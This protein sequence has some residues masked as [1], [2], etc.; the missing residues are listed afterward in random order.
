MSKTNLTLTLLMIL[1][2]GIA[3]TIIYRDSIDP[4]A[5]GES[6]IQNSLLA[7]ALLA[8]IAFLTRMI[9]QFRNASKKSMMDITDLKQRLDNDEIFLLDVRTDEDYVG[10]QGHIAGSVQ[11]PVEQ[12]EQRLA[13][14]SE[15]FGDDF[16]KS[17]VTICRTDRKSAKASQILSNN[18]FTN[19]YIARMG[20]TD[21]IKNGYPIKH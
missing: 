5:G 8:I 1:S 16:D 15:M 18:G 11:I 9:S 7:L 14:L 21:W 20:M 2:I 3:L 4:V 19:N 13:E 17:I 10:E 12:L 6:L